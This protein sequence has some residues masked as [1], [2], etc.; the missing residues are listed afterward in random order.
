MSLLVLVL[1]PSLWQM[2]L[3]HEETNIYEPV[4]LSVTALSMADGPTP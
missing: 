3:L 4:G 2:A 1:L